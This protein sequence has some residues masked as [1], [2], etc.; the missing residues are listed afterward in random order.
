M[1]SIAFQEK[2][3]TAITGKA[4][5]SFCQWWFKPQDNRKVIRS[6]INRL[7]TLGTVN[8]TPSFR[9]SSWTHEDLS[10]TLFRNEPKAHAHELGPETA[11][12]QG[13]TS[14]VFRKSLASGTMN[15]SWMSWEQELSRAAERYKAMLKEIKSRLREI[16][17][18]W[19]GEICHHHLLYVSSVQNLCWLMLSIVDYPKY[20]GSWWSNRG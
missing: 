1:N 19:C 10:R 17:G 13:S 18:S 15:Q 9:G 2:D 20:W 7:D 4:I 5:G 16:I 14:K 3:S 11:N 8:L 12:K 6:V